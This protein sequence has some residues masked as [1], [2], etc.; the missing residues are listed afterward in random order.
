MT[1]PIKHSFFK[2]TD[3]LAYKIHNKIQFQKTIYITKLGHF[4]PDNSVWNIR[5]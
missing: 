1:M 2:L 4:Y 5:G 3:L